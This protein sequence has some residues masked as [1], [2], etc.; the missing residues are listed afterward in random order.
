MIDR[1]TKDTSSVL[2]DKVIII[3]GASSG[4]GKS[5][6]LEVASKGAK[7]VISSHNVFELA[8][9]EKEINK[10][11]GKC[12]AIVADVTRKTDC[13]K[14]V[15]KTIEKY[16]QEFGKYVVCPQIASGIPGN[17]MMEQGSLRR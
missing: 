9:A 3:T 14:L 6:A 17:W 10:L 16:S 15:E 4:I 5:L 1:N 2:K 7:V 13:K 12:L 8:L 11:G